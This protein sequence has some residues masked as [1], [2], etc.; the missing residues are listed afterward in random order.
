MTWESKNHE[1]FAASG[2]RTLVQPSL[3]MKE[4]VE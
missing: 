3:F 2:W 1:A 4:A